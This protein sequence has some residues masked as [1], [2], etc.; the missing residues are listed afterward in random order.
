MKYWCLAGGDIATKSDH[1][2]LR[3]P[4]PLPRLDYLETASSVRES[5]LA[6]GAPGVIRR[7]SQKRPRL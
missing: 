1:L 6:S 3:Y 2:K 7:D 5:L 4:E